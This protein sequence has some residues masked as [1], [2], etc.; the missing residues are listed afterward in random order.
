L[1]QKLKEQIYLINYFSELT[2]NDPSLL[3]LVTGAE[4]IGLKYPKQGS[5][6]RLLDRDGSFLKFDEARLSSSVL[7][8]GASSEIFG[9]LYRDQDIYFKLKWAI[10]GL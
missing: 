7:A 8:I 10:D 1:K 5:K 9:G 4:A 2:K 3:V 6:W